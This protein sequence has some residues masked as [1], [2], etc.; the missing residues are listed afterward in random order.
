[1]PPH[2]LQRHFTSVLVY[3]PWNWGYA[4]LVMTSLRV[5]MAAD[6][7]QVVAC[8]RC[9]ELEA[10]VDQLQREFAGR[11]KYLENVAAAQRGVIDSH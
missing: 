4:I 3:H 6:S 10:L 11:Q 9:R 7:T 5:V 8:P 1:M 2:S